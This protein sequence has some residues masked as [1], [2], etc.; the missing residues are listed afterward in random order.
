MPRVLHHA[1]AD[2]VFYLAGADPHEDD[3]GG[4]GR[5]IDDTVAVHL[6]TVEVAATFV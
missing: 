5:N 1:R 2:V 4:Y 3:A 6:G